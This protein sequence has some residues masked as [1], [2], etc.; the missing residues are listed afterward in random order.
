MSKPRAV[1][2]NEELIDRVMQDPEA[3]LIARAIQQRLE[4]E[5]KKRE[6][7]YNSMPAEEQKVEFINGEVIIHSLVIKRHNDISTNI[8]QLLNTFVIKYDLG[9]VGH[10][11][12]MIRLTR[13]DYEPDVCYFDREQTATFAD[14]TSL[15]PP[16]R[17]VVEVLSSKTAGRDRGIKFEDYEKH[18]IPE[19]WIVVPEEASVE[20]YLLEEATATYRLRKKSDSGWIEVAALNP[21][22]LPIEAMFDAKK[23]QAVIAEML[24][25]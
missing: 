2:L 20:Q 3:P 14:E 6:A 25:G 17:L 15:F 18:R 22:K 12:I 11:K 5:Q 8:F 1:T 24:A 23:T 4:E 13:N 21:L 10:E 7:F 19:Y 9:F 16:P